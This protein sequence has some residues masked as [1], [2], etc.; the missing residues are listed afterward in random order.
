MAAMASLD[1]FLSG[2]KSTNRPARLRAR[3]ILFH[4]FNA[5]GGAREVVPMIVD[6]LPGLIVHLEGAHFGSSPRGRIAHFDGAGAGGEF[7]TAARNHANQ[8]VVREVRRL[9][10]VKDGAG[11]IVV[12]FHYDAS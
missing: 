9:N 8:F 11:W 12:V 1:W 3:W 7:A 6:E 2:W 5:H 4:H 10:L